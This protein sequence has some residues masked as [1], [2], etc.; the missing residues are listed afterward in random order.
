MLNQSPLRDFHKSHGGVFVEREGGL[1]PMH[2]GD[3][4]A[5]YG[6][7][8]AHVGLI[9][10]PQRAFISLTGPD[11]TSYLQGLFSN[12]VSS[13]TPGHGRYGAF[14]NQQG[15]VLSDARVWCLENSFL[16][17]LPHPYKDTILT[18]LNRY[19]VADNVEIADRSNDSGI[20][21]LQ[22]FHSVT[23]AAQLVG[24]SGLPEKPLDH[25]AISIAGLQVRVTRFSHT[26]M[27]GFDFI[28]STERMSAFATLV[29]DIGKAY[30]ARWVGEQALETLRIEAGIPRYGIDITDETLL[31]ETGMDHAVSFVKGC[32]LGQ[33]VM[34]RIR[35]RGHVNKK[36]TGLLLD[37]SQTPQRGNLVILAGQKIGTITSATHSL[38]LGQPVA[39]AYIHR[40]H[41]DP[42]T[43]VEVELA[44]GPV[45]ALVTGLPF[46]P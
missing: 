10:L 21:T 4:R 41:W 5:E 29:T 9:E 40:E 28:V 24:P 31:L 45:G 30:S 19:L 46:A 25:S 20:I 15:K 11:R 7:V 18:H 12:D 17:D 42:G 16:L 44:E 37:G 6:A 3:A 8:R 39:L 23:M 14:L 43:R 32:Y 35:S 36:L 26:G 22:G 34:E 38:M 2:F 13:L 27:D 1:L 33:E